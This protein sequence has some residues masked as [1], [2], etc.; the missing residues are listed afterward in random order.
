MQRKLT[1]YADC[2]GCAS[3]LGAAELEALMDDLPRQTDER[4]I[5]DYSTADDAGVYRWGNGRSLVQTVD[6]F[7]PIVDDPY[8]FGQIA[9]ANALSDVYAMGGIPRTA[10]AVAAMPAKDGPSANE[11]RAIFRGGS[12]MLR[13]A[14]VAL[15][16]GHTVT[17][18]E[19]KF[20]Y[21]ITGEVADDRVLTNAGA[22]AGDVL[23]LTKP[24]G[25]GIIVRA[26]KYGQATEDELGGAVRSMCR[27]NRAAIEALDHLPP[28]SVHACT[29][30]TGFGLAGHATEMATA[31]GVRLVIDADR[32]P[33]LPGAVRLVQDY[34]PCGGRANK[35]HFTS[36]QVT[37]SVP[38]AMHLICLDPQTSGGLLL[39]VAD[40]A[41][42][43][44]LGLLTQNG[45]AAK[46]IGFVEPKR[47]TEHH[48]RLQ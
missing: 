42:D 1:D 47:P 27:L 23:I 3:K 41:A 28:D 14:G 33:L 43:R 2:A 18:P 8:V 7:T 39:S 11:I 34:L 37:D 31:S 36:L 6:F 25:T 21:A 19:V 5:V 29:D 12:D 4:I 32:L 9:A 45:D 13:E 48:V 46:V 15:L 26:R 38:M 40:S 24:L 44:L 22:R 17:D 30:I 20:G 35:R 10:L 16:G